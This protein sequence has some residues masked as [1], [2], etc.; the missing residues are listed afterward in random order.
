MY[1]FIVGSLADKY[2]EP[3]YKEVPA[4]IASG[5]FKLKEDLKH[6]LEKA[7]EAI[8][9]VQTGKNKGKSVIIV[10]EE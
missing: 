5:E 6:G 2:E 9:D 8:L 4:K 1:G 3:F 10:A 7:G